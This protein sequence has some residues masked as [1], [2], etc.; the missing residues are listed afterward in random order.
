MATKLDRFLHDLMQ[1]VED[2]LRKGY[3]VE[4]LRDAV[5]GMGARTE[6]FFKTTLLPQVSPKLDLDGCINALKTFGVSKDD[7][8][9]LHR[10]RMLYNDCKH[11][12]GY[13]PS[14]VEIQTLLPEVA[15][16]FRTIGAKNIGS[17]NSVDSR[18][19]RR[20]LWIAVWDH[21]IGGDSEV[22]LVIPMSGWL[23]P[24]LDMVYIGMEFWDTAKDLLATAGVV[25]PGAATIPEESLR[26]FAAEDDFRE[27][28]VYE[29]DYRAAMAILAMY[30]RRVDGLLPGLRRE[31]APS[32]MIQAFS[33]A[34][35]DVAGQ[36]LDGQDASSLIAQRV[37]QTYAVPATYNRMSTYADAFG[38]MILQIPQSSREGL[39][40][41]AW[42]TA[43]EFNQASVGALAK[44]SEIPVV[45]DS[46]GRLLIR[47]A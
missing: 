23:P 8:Q 4:Q 17:M 35:L 15:T 25:R 33:M 34:A 14:L 42:V 11:T 20:V 39:S 21:Y 46:Q 19:Y 6:L 45:I 47:V 28:I 7:R 31:D 12:P 10:F 3:E 27:A 18:K 41:P 2:L 13:L 40:G 37:S 32:S 29:G 22:H 16:V 30:E 5:T 43:E 26:Q 36:I 1:P 44:D 24:S 9:T 38:R